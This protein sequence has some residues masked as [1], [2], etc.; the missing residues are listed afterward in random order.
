V[1]SDYVFE[2]F[3]CQGGCGGEVVGFLGCDFE[4]WV[5]FCGFFS[6]FGFGNSG[7]FNYDLDCFSPVYVCDEA[8]LSVVLGIWFVCSNFTDF[9]PSMAFP[10]FILV[11]D[12]FD[13]LCKSDMVLEVV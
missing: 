8:K 2:L 12:Y 7:N 5:L 3:G 9:Y 11:G 13:W 4:D 6:V 10:G 1:V